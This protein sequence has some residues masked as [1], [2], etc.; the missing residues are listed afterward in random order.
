MFSYPQLSFYITEHVMDY[1]AE[2]SQKLIKIIRKII[3]MFSKYLKHQA[4][5]KC[6]L[7][8]SM[9]MQSSLTFYLW[10]VYVKYSNRDENHIF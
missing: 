8:F 5:I 6:C 4:Y 9:N 2:I 7:M 10:H 1:C 3:L